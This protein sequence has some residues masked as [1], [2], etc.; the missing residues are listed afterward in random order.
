MNKNYPVM[1]ILLWKIRIF[2]Q[3]KQNKKGKIKDYIIILVSLK[4]KY[5]QLAQQGIL[6]MIA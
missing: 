5:S 1:G 2:P 6:H 3:I 4:P